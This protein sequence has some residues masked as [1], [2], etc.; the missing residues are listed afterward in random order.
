MKKITSAISI[1]GLFFC[2]SDQAYPDSA[3]SIAEANNKFSMRFY[4]R[5][6]EAGKGNQFF[7]PFSILCAFGMVYEGA[8]GKTAEEIRSVFF[9]PSEKDERLNGFLSINS[10]L[11]ERKDGCTLRSANAYWVQKNYHILESYSQLIKKYYRGE[12]FDLDFLSAPDEA[13]NKINNWVDKKTEGKIKKL[14]SDSDINVQ[15]RLILTNAIYFKGMWKIPF[16][17]KATEPDDF[18]ISKN[19]SVKVQMMQL[20]DREFPYAETEEFQIIKIPYQCQNLS[21]LI[22]LPKKNE[23]SILNSITYEKLVEMAAID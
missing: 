9:L 16:D 12:S 21:M 6:T 4:S 15:T 22:I 7:S 5:I 19:N 23:S 13:L 17:R 3:A 14:V 18:W 8:N 10:L 11:N 2:L 20:V 1:I